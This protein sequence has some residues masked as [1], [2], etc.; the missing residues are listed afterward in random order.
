[1]SQLEVL[2]LLV[3]A[4]GLLMLRPPPGVHTAGEKYLVV[5]FPNVF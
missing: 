3:Q 1:M 5:Q 4:F 2:P